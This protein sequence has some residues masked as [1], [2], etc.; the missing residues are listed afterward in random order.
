MSELHSSLAHAADGIDDNGES[1]LSR[2]T[3]Q[4]K[5]L[6]FDEVLVRRWDANLVLDS[7]RHPFAVQ[8]LVV[9]GSLWLRV[10]GLSSQ[11]RAGC[12]FSLDQD[13][14][15]TE[16]YGPEGAVFWVARRHAKTQP[17]QQA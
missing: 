13:V 7:H 10:A 4:A 2:F 6:G 11:L 5:R 14:T 12:R 15:H 3:E 17:E 8:A 1:S 9:E 16:H